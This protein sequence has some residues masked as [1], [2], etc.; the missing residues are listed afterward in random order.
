MA[1]TPYAAALQQAQ[2]QSQ[3]TQPAY[4]APSMQSAQAVGLQSAA[5]PMA[6]AYANLYARQF[7]NSMNRGN[8]NGYANLLQVPA[9]SSMAGQGAAKVATPVAATPVAAPAAVAD[10]YYGTI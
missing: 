3:P 1:G 9:A 5:H 10:P 4:S 7:A 6:N 8:M 2:A